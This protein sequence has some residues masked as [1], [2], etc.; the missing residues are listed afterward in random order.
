MELKIFYQTTD[1]LVLITI[2][3]WYLVGKEEIRIKCLVFFPKYI[4]FQV[5]LVDTDP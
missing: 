5:P 4:H 1:V 2:S 3:T